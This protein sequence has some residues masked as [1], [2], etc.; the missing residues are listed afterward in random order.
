FIDLYVGKRIPHTA[1]KLILGAPSELAGLFGETDVSNFQF[2]FNTWNLYSTYQ[3]ALTAWEAQPEVHIR[4]ENGG[5]TGKEGLPIATADSRYAAWPIPGTIPESHY[6][7]PDGQLGTAAPA[8]ADTDARS[9]STYTYDP[10]SKRAHSFDGGSD[11]AW[12]RHPDVHWNPLKEGDSLSFVTPAYS[13]ETAY[14]GTGSVDLWVASSAADTDLEATLTEVRPDGKEMFIQSGWLRASHRKLDDASSTALLPQQTNL[15][16]DAQP[17]PAGQFVPVRFALFPFAHVVRPGSRLR[18]NI[19]APGGNQDFWAFSD[20]AGTATN[21]IGHSTDMPSKVVLPKLPSLPNVPSTVPA[22]TL[23][24]V[25]TQAVSLRN[26]PCRDYLPA[27]VPTGVTGTALGSA[28][29]VTWTAPAGTA[30]DG[31]RITPAKP[32]GGYDGGPVPGP[33]TTTGAGTTATFPSVPPDEP[34]EFTVEALYGASYAPASDASMP[35][36]ADSLVAPTPVAASA[37]RGSAN[38]TWTAPTAVANGA[39]VTGY[40]VTPYSGSTPL[41]AQSFAADA[42]GGVVTGLTNGKAYT[43]KVA[44]TN[45]SGPGAVATTGAV[46]PNKVWPFNDPTTFVKRQLND[47][48]GS[49]PSAKVTAGVAAVNGGQSAEA[50]IVSLRHGSDG[51]SIV[52]PVTRL[53]MAYFLR[54][55]DPGG[56]S[57]WTAA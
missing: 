49:A 53:Y 20:L 33:I 2:P 55:P 11:A 4:W 36:A 22:C 26:Q 32:T 9:A 48:T 8:I 57:H 6:L 17:I 35:V 44:A 54:N 50:Y 39:P 3:Q 7:E 41:A 37:R 18:L 21:R 52:D 34:L 25:T 40:R 13:A 42:S 16:G 15:A 27:R 51:T 12:T 14:A 56:L 47:F 30:P 23:A 31:Y 28:V 45:V 19:E 29:H 24:G 1:A 38:V 46:T 5:V 10:T 43:F